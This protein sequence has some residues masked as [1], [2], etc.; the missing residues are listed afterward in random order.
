MAVFKSVMANRPECSPLREAPPGGGLAILRTIYIVARI[1]PGARVFPVTYIVCPGKKGSI[2]C[3]GKKGSIFVRAKRVY[4]CLDLSSPKG[5]IY[6][7]CSKKKG[8]I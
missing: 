7:G 2:N 5:A 1:F 3:P 8:T 4:P 6:T